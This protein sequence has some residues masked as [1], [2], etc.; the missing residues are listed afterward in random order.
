MMPLVGRIVNDIVGTY[1]HLERVLMEAEEIKDESEDESLLAAKEAEAKVLLDQFQGYVRELERLGGTIKDYQYGLVD[2]CG[3]FNGQVVYYCWS[4]GE[5]PVNFW[6]DAGK[7]CSTR[8]TLDGTKP[9][10]LK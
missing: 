2:F 7:E 4:P 6:H 10:L 1:R 9:K 3:D 5:E 8:V